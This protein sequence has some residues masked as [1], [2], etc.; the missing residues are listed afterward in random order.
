MGNN[1]E[2]YEEISGLRIRIKEIQLKQKE[3][4]RE[5]LNLDI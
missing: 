1:I 3:L 4:R 2:P 5:W